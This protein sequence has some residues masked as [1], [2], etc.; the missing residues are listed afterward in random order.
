MQ[1][2]NHFNSSMVRLKDKA[3]L[4]GIKAKI[5]QFLDGAIKSKIKRSSGSFTYNFNSSMVRLK[6]Q[7]ISNT[8]SVLIFQ[9]LDGAIK[10]I[11]SDESYVCSVDFNSSMVRLKA[12]Q[13]FRIFVDITISI[14]RWC[15]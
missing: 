2:N 11:I 13:Q 15:D 4:L 3:F 7:F 9:F 14:P 12:L 8:Q 1:G 6:D 5:F 10:S